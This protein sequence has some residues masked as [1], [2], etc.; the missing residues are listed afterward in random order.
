MKQTPLSPSDICLGAVGERKRCAEGWGEDGAGYAA[1]TPNTA[2]VVK[3]DAWLRANRVGED[4][5][6]V[7]FRFLHC[8]WYFSGHEQVMDFCSRLNLQN[9][10]EM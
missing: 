8:P 9:S 7:E 5:K 2:E 3:M 10:L 4:Q 1:P 6:T